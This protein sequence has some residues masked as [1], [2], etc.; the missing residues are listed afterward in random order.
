MSFTEANYENVILELFRKHFGY[1]YIYGPDVYRNYIEPFYLEVLQA[2]LQD[3]N[4]S[5]PQVASPP[6]G[7]SYDYGREDDYTLTGFIR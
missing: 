5:L 6:S 3:L 4:S 2:S 7:R 1:D